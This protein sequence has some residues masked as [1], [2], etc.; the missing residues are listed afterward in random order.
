MTDGPTIPPPPPPSTGGSSLVTR[1]TNILTKPASEWQVIENEPATI[2]G[3]YTGYVAILAAIPAIC[4]IIGQQVFGWSYGGLVTVKLPIVYTLVN[5]ILYY[6]LTLGSVYVQA[7]VYDAL[8]P[9]FGGTKD[10]LKA[11]KVAAYSGT[12]AWL[13]GVFFILPAISFLAF[14]LALYSLYLLFLGLPRLMRAPEDKAIVYVV[15]AVVVN[16]VLM[17]VAYVL[18]SKIAE[19]FLTPAALIG[20]NSPY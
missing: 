7:L 6:A 8:A 11:F 17:G 15:V 5:A 12:A 16:A 2:S 13:S 10:S 20:A 1:V 4:M 18:A 3:I 19:M 14:I 9:N